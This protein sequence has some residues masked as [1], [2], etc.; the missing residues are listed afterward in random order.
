MISRKLINNL[1][2]IFFW[3]FLT[4]MILSL[5]H[6]AFFF[7][8]FHFNNLIKDSHAAYIIVTTVLVMVNMNIIGGITLYQLHEINDKLKIKNE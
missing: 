7:L 1:K 4:Y 6:V 3:A 8:Y 5:I 2:K